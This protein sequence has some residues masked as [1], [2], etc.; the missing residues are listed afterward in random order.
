MARRRYQQ[1]T[2]RKR[3]KRDPQWELQWR[4][5]YIKPDGGIGRRLVT[6]LL[7]RVEDMTR[8][9]AQKAAQELLRP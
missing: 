7:G 5:D 1:G 8:R 3:G 6:H 2:L 4:E 9:Q